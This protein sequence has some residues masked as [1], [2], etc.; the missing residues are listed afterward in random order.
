VARPRGMTDATWLAGAVIAVPLLGAL[1]SVLAGRRVERTG[2]PIALLALGATT[3][4]TA[5]LAVEIVNTGSVRATLGGGG[6]VE[7]GVRA[8]A[9]SAIIALLDVVLALGALAYTRHAGPRGNRFYGGYLL[10]V[11]SVLAI[12]LAGDLLTLYLGVQVMIAAS[13]RL[14]TS[15]DS[16]RAD[17]AARKLLVVGSV[18]SG[19][20]LLGAALLARATGSIYMETVAEGVAAIGYSD[21]PVVAAFV[22]SAGGLA[23]IVAMVPFHTWLAEAHA[24]APDAVS[25]LLSGVVPAAGV[26]A[27]V[28]VVYTVFTAE[29]LGANR[30]VVMGLIG[31][32][33]VTVLIG[34]LFALAQ[35]EIKL[36]LAYSTISQFG[37]VIAGL[38]IANETA[39]FGAIF[40]LVGHG[41]VKGALCVV[42]GILFVR[43]GAKSLEEYAGLAKRMPVVGA[44]FVALGIAMIGL[45]PTVGFVGKWYIA[46]GAI[47][48][49][50]WP[51]AGVVL[52]S[53]LFSLG[54]VVPFIDR[55]Y[56]HRPD[57][58]AERE[59]GGTVTRWTLALVALAAASAFAI[60][61]SSAWIESLLRPA[62]DDLL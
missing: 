43:F 54:Y 40:Q 20:Y 53:T 1:C 28:R 39:V 23:V 32:G 57:P 6:F 51:V 17:Y 26:Y 41:L 10:F 9:F 3:L 13:A 7:I 48:A 19:V 62:I 33:V 47:E 24:V 35:T 30:A 46:L 49:G 50:L 45:P 42:A 55:L 25:A 31:F 59:A 5:W 4:L 38:A 52:V 27:F 15:A 44:S 34:S 21:P 36:M 2:W 8:D 56:F 61:L 11:A 14:V 12:T 22:A 60:G 16:Q 37:L 58:N 29:F 18:G